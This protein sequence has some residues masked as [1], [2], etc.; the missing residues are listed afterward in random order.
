MGIEPLSRSFR[1]R[2]ERHHE[3]L[4]VYLLV[5]ESVIVAFAAEETFVAEARIEGQPVGR[6]SIKPWGDGRWFMELTAA[7]RGRLDLRIGQTVQVSLT[8]A[9]AEPD[10]L[11]RAITRCRLDAAWQGLTAARRRALCEGV[12]EAR[13][14][15][16]REAR[17]ERILTMLRG[18]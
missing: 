16:T 5:P 4:P 9:P 15:A 7:H 1:S 11:R 3:D 17:I 13:R 8:E 6:R 12:F 14:P 18:D 10:A 2:L